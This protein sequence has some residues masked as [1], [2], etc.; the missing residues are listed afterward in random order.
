MKKY[1][2]SRRAFLRLALLTGIG[3]GV[4]ALNELTQPVG[5]V[6]YF[7]WM[8][9]GK[10]QQF[11]GKPAV[12]ALMEC[13]N[14]QADVTAAVRDVWQ[15]AEMPDVLGKKVLIKPNLIDVIQGQNTTTAPQVVGAVIDVLRESGAAEIVVGDGPGFHQD[16][17][18][19]ARNSGILETVE[20]R[21][22]KFIDLNYDDP[23]PIPVNDGWLRR[24]EVLWLPRH[25]VEADL[26]VSVPKLKCHHWAGVTL[27]LKNLFG[28][29]PGSRY[30]WPKNML[31]FNSISASI[32]GIYRMLPQMVSVVD[33]IVGME[34][35]GPLFGSPVAHGMLAAGNDPLA[36]DVTCAGLMG[37]AL[38]EIEHL[39]LGAWAGVGQAAQIELRGVDRARFQ[40]A[41]QRPP[42]L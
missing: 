36:V 42:K 21:G 22:V 12:V 38:E 17:R 27:S 7:R 3:A 1:S 34:G 40:R 19:V 20:Q 8:G 6:T 26:I 30:G 29:V 39:A 9:S 15:L 25:V 28:V 37:F 2:L 4:V 32:L 16:A 11:F 14:Y 24:E 18:S 23:Q 5:P 35:D 13:A 41:Y 33:G 10:Y 31:H